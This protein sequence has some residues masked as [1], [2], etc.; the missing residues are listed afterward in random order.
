MVGLNVQRPFIRGV[1]AVD[2]GF[3]WCSSRGA[4]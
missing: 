1:V 3:D 4:L 2:R